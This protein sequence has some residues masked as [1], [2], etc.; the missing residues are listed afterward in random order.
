MAYVAPAR[1]R[2][3][4][5]D[6]LDALSRR[7]QLTDREA[8]RLAELTFMTQRRGFRLRYPLRSNAA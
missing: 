2:E 1:A 6:R 4:E 8:D 7:R 3:I 5:M